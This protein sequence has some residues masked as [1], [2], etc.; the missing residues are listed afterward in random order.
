MTSVFKC[1]GCRKYCIKKGYIWLEEE[2]VTA[3][4][5]RFQITEEAFIKKY[6]RNY[7]FD[8]A[9]LDNPHSDDSILLK[10]KKFCEACEA[11]LK[12]GRTFPSWT[13]NLTSVNKWK[14][15]KGECARNRPPQSSHRLLFKN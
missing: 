12:Q 7:L 15:A 9:L 14:K 5:K 6:T 13:K 8:L 10:N 11:R 3:L 1:I 4:A 2:G